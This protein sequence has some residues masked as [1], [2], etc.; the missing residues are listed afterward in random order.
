MC[1]KVKTFLFTCNVV[2]EFA[3]TC[4]LQSLNNLID[5]VT[6]SVSTTVVGYDLDY[7][8]QWWMSK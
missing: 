5:V 6:N 3:K 1:L 7:F 8:F 2:Q 4:S